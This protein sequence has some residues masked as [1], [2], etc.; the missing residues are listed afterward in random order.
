MKM[1]SSRSWQKEYPADQLSILHSILG[2]I[3]Y[4]LFLVQNLF[5]SHFDQSASIFI[6]HY[7]RWLPVIQIMLL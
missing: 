3:L 6:F 1:I 2:V 4:F 5:L 7:G